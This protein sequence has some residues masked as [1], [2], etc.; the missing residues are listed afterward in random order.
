[1]FIGYAIG[2]ALV[3][4]AAVIAWRWAVDAERKPLEQIS[5][6]LDALGEEHAR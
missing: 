4:A 6:P 3:L 2:A 1:V 5:P